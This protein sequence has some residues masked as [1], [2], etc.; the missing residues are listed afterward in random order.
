MEIKSKQIKFIDIFLSGLIFIGIFTTIYALLE[1]TDVVPYIALWKPE[2]MNW[3]VYEPN[4]T[5]Q[6][7]MFEG[8]IVFCITFEAIWIVS[9]L[10]YWKIRGYKIK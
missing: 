1:R 4:T 6:L 3:N 9:Q 5:L 10:G 8:I 7:N 2:W